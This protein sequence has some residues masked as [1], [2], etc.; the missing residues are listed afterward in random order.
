MLAIR[1]PIAI[2]ERLDKLSK[3]TGRT[4]TY[5]AREAI[6]EK[7]EELEDLYYAEKIMKRIKKVDRSVAIR[8][9]KFLYE[10]IAHLSDPRSVGEALKGPLREYW[11]YRVG[12]YRLVA[13]IEDHD[14]EILILRV[15][16]R[17]EVYR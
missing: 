11:K 7:L 3:A 13:S 6:L 16:N 2:E 9:Q 17:R 10:R 8:I 4:K 12:D 5:Y 14:I 15:G 1:L